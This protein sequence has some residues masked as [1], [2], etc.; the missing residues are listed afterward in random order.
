MSSIR[1]SVVV[2][3]LVSG[4][5]AFAQPSRAEHPAF[6]V[7]PGAKPINGE[8]F[9]EDSGQTVSEWYVEHYPAPPGMERP[10]IS[11]G[12]T[13]GVTVERRLDM[14]IGSITVSATV[15]QETPKATGGIGRCSTWQGFNWLYG[16]VKQSKSSHDMAEFEQLCEKYQYLFH[17]Q[18][19]LEKPGG[20]RRMDSVVYDRYYKLVEQETGARKQDNADTADLMQKMTEAIKRGDMAEAKRLKTEMRNAK[21]QSQTAA[22]GEVSPD[23]KWDHWVGFL[24]ELTKYTHNTRIVLG[25]HP[26]H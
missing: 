6:E 8:Y 16:I 23:E 10:V 12:S 24:E 5:L 9:T 13:I 18:Y 21:K 11:K 17:S 3:T 22:A 19:A 15:R 20:N 2:V 26:P 4:C 1:K 14:D 7:Y 25:A